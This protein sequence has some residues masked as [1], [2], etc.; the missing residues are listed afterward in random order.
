[1]HQAESGNNNEIDELHQMQKMA[2]TSSFVPA[3][4]E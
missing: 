3:Q 2:F 1:M 4:R